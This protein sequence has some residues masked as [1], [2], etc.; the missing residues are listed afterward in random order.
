MHAGLLLNQMAMDWTRLMLRQG[1]W[2][3]DFQQAV[4]RFSSMAADGVSAAQAQAGGLLELMG[5]SIRV[6][7]GLLR[8]ASA[9]AQASGLLESQ[10]RWIGFWMSA[11][12]LA[13]SNASTLAR[14]N[15]RAWTSWARL[16]QNGR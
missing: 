11:F 5:R 8:Q 16:G 10:S 6:K 9:A 2:S 1:E 3:G 12:H 7:A 15:G 4:E 13:C 14:I